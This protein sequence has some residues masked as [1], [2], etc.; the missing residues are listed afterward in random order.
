MNKS[1][2]LL[3]WHE[4]WQPHWSKVRPSPNELDPPGE[5]NAT[6]WER[7]L[8]ETPRT[9]ARE[10]LRLDRITIE[11]SHRFHK[12]YNLAPAVT[13]FGSTRFQ[14]ASEYCRQ[15]IEVGR[16]ADE[17]PGGRQA[18]SIANL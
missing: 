6:V 3:F 10:K 5:V 13:A 15:G 4:E 9:P 12:L 18:M 1:E 8:L 2:K 7:D 14:E 17:A 11:F 16:L